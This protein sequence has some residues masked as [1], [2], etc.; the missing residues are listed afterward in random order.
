MFTAWCFNAVSKPLCGIAGTEIQGA[1]TLMYKVTDIEYDLLL[2]T[3]ASACM[4]VV[5]LLSAIRVM[6]VV[7]TSLEDAD[8]A[9]LNK[10]GDGEGGLDLHKQKTVK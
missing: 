9:V 1:V 7:I 5:M 3:C 6:T 10:R 4:L 2:L 8:G